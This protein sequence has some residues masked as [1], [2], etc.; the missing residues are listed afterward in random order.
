MQTLS[1]ILGILAIVGMLL[2]F[3]PCLGW[4]NWFNIPLAGVGLII[5]VIAL[6]TGKQGKKGG[7]IAGVI[8]CAIAVFFGLV[9]LIAGGGVF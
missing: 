2:G 5:S 3:F 8:C 6:A 1:L 4:W 9:R 7:S